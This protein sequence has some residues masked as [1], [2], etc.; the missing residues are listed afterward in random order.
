MSITSK[1]SG[2]F[3]DKEFQ[4]ILRN[5]IPERNEFYTISG[6][7]SFS[8][9]YIMKVPSELENRGESGLVGTAFDYLARFIVA[10]KINK[11]KEG[12][13]TKTIAEMA[14]SWIELEIEDDE[15][16]Y[17]FDERYKES[18]K[19]IKE[20]IYGNDVEI[21][22][23]LI[24]S[25]CYFARLDS[26]VRARIWLNNLKEFPLVNESKDIVDE[27]TRLIN[28]FIDTF[29]KS[30]LVKEN[31]DVVFNPEF[32]ICTKKCGGADADIFIDGVLYD[33][34]SS[35]NRGYRWQDVAQLIGYYLFNEIATQTDSKGGSLRG[36]VI[37]K[38]AI[39]KAR[40]GEIECFDIDNIDKIKK[41]ISINLLLDNLE[42]EDIDK[43]KIS[44]NDMNKF[45][46]ELNEREWKKQKIT[47]LSGIKRIC[48]ICKEEKALED[49]EKSGKDSKGNIKYKHQCKKCRYELRR[50]K[51]Q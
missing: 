11:N 33:F 15:F 31:S 19:I 43:F 6:K 38:I 25:A 24:N 36:Y 32:G 18:I 8:N 29:I 5:I 45:N 20:Y 13:Y 14:L 46:E 23:K 41:N 47:K 42:I 51:S 3:P 10:K 17:K 26:V 44:K 40:Y 7:E 16:F 48:T 9:S 2:Q 35:K 1:L 50:K 12:A 37:D 4:R 49:F 28:L 34:K 30:D 22:E 39:Y 27:L 21:N